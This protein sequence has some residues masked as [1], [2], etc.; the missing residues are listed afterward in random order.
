MREKM[1][2]TK[3]S[4]MSTTFVTQTFEAVVNSK[5]HVPLGLGHV[6][7]VKSYY[8]FLIFCGIFVDKS[9]TSLVT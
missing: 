9:A 7:A 6:T 5:L 1:K 2:W 8:K 4:G 3:T